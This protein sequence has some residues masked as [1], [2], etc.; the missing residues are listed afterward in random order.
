MRLGKQNQRVTAEE[1]RPLIIAVLLAMLVFLQ[2][3]E[4]AEGPKAPMRV[5]GTP[6]SSTEFG[7]ETF[8]TVYAVLEVGDFLYVMPSGSNGML[9]V[10]DLNGNYQQSLF[11]EASGKGGFAL[12]ADGDVLYVED[13]ND[14]VY[15]FENGEFRE[16]VKE[17]DAERRFAHIQFRH[18]G[19]TP[20]YEIRSGDL[21]R[22]SDGNEV[23]LISELT[24]YGMSAAWTLLSA[25]P[26]IGI[27]WLTASYLKRR[28][29]AH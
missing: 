22:V 20:G 8:S 16:F 7:D 3:K 17:K 26:P 28:R 25:V 19:G 27:L 18:Q 4:V 2:I 15:V 5:L 6:V 24:D 29:T 12:G 23:L 14:N 21:W 10:Y 13:I 9:Q 1:F 11:F